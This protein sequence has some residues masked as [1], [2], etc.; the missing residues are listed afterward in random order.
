MYE[1]KTSKKGY[2]PGMRGLVS[3]TENEGSDEL[4]DR[5]GRTKKGKANWQPKTVANLAKAA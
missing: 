3:A 2:N 1:Q 4:E 5:G